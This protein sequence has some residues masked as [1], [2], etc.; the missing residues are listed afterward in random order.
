MP[1][2][3]RPVAP[4]NRAEAS[5][6]G[7][8]LPGAPS[9]PFHSLAKGSPPSTACWNQGI[10]GFQQGPAWVVGGEVGGKSE[11]EGGGILLGVELRVGMKWS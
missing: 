11:N 2:H 5:A 10:R 4:S 6:S 9:S 3:T 1:N 8:T 7:A